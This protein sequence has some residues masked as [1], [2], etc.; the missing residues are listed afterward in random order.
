ML[1]TEFERF[2]TTNWSIVR[3]AGGTSCES[4]RRALETLF[5]RYWFP[6][7]AYVRRNGLDE[8]AAKDMVQSFVASLLERNDLEIVGPEKGKFRTFLLVSLKNFLNNDFK[9][10]RAQKR[11]GHLKI[12]SINWEQAE[13]RIP[14]P[15]AQQ[16]PEK[17]FEKE[18]GLSLIN[19]TLSDL[20]TQY[21]DANKLEV[22]EELSSFLIGHRDEGGSYLVAGR[23]L[24]MSES[25]TKSAIFRMR[26][27]YRQL[28]R[29][30]IAETVD[31]EQAIDEEIKEL[32]RAIQS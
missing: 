31:N 16:S 2:A 10:Q 1:V 27:T 7:Y 28:L 17:L 32:F 4:S 15:V 22:F 5:E 6:L 23:R 11:G 18:W 8:N 12:L 30:H 21:R 14:E 9:R 25:A 19:Q 3:A 29:S 26:Q 24:N 13:R 20:K